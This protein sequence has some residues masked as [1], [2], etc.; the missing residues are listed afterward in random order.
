MEY[1]C[2]QEDKDAKDECSYDQCMN[3]DG[4]GEC[5]IEECNMR[6]A[7]KEYTC[8]RWEYV[9]AENFWTAT[10]CDEHHDE[11]G[12]ID[13]DFIEFVFGHAGKVLT[14]YDDTLGL[15]AEHVVKPA[16]ED[17]ITDNFDG[18]TI[19]AFLADEAAVKFTSTFLKDT[20]EMLD[21]FGMDADLDWAHEALEAENHEELLDMFDHVF[22]DF[23][24]ND[25][26]GDWSDHE[27]EHSDKDD[28]DMQDWSEEGEKSEWEDDGNWNKTDHDDDECIR[29]EKSDCMDIISDHVNGLEHCAYEE[30]VDVCNK[31]VVSCHVHVTVH[32]Q[33]VEGECDEMLAIFD[34]DPEDLEHHDDRENN[35]DQDADRDNQDWN[36]EDFNMDDWNEE[37]MTQTTRNS[38]WGHSPR[39]R[40]H[41]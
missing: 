24:G 39:G 29:H 23:W 21:A 10:D 33:D 40:R 3:K 4:S 35:A 34:I 13:M 18:S 16:I 1:D 36:E 14:H 32:G 25:D 38:A 27:G 15:V 19:D 41:H 28:G 26:E 37:D 11:K 22:E 8:T 7:C 5:W 17:A 31:E 2:Q 6:D 30:I 20:D 12:D 9:A